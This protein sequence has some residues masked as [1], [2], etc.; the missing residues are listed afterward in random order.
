MPFYIVRN[1]DDWLIFTVFF[2]PFMA[3]KPV[4]FGY[5]SRYC[6]CRIPVLM[7]FLAA[8]AGKKVNRVWYCIS[9]ET[10]INGLHKKTFGRKVV[11]LPDPYYSTLDL[12]RKREN[13]QL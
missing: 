12:S 5:S 7:P 4:R 13:S 9:Q 6:D 3:G 11:V 8:L 2:H 1:V 10:W